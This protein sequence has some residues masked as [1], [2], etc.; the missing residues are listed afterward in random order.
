MTV[1]VTRSE[2]EILIAVLLFAEGAALEMSPPISEALKDLRPW[3]TALLRTYLA[4]QYVV[5]HAR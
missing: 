3:R 4:S 1:E 2:A 5:N